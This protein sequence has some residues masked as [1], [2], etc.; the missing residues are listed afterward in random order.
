MLFSLAP[1]RPPPQKKKKNIVN[2]KNR[3]LFRFLPFP[4]LLSLQARPREPPLDHH[5][6]PRRV[7]ER[8]SP[9]PPPPLGRLH[10]PLVP[11]AG[12]PP[13]DGLAVPGE[14][15]APLPA[16]DGLHLAALGPALLGRGGGRGAHGADAR[17]GE[18]AGGR[19]GGRG[20]GR[21]RGED[22][23]GTAP[24][25]GRRSRRSAPLLPAEEEEVPGE[26]A[27]RRRRIEAGAAKE[28]R[29]RRRRRRREGAGS[30]GRRR[31][32]RRHRRRSRRRR[33]PPRSANCARRAAAAATQPGER[34]G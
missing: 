17:D 9:Q 16:G 14:L 24:G 18:E 4:F 30:E 28:R 19:R 6:R 10:H 1:Q 2:N 15:E 34:R 31:P 27:R 25:G 20:R 11:V 22:G 8:R 12:R 26:S 21:G 29:R 23:D 13:R 5:V 32:G 33:R 3:I 7:H